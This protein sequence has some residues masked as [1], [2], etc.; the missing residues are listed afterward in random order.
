MSRCLV[1]ALPFALVA[2]APA[3]SLAAEECPDGWFCEDNAAPR[4]ASPPAPP[5]TTRPA[6]PPLPP[7]AYNSPSYPPPGYY[8]PE[9]H[10]DAPDNPP[11]KLR[12]RRSDREWGFNLHLEAAIL[13]NKP[14]RAANTG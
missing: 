12:R 13:G 14:E 11:A 8:E 2:L 9:M 6:P 7:S 1:F 3:T 4:P 10:F 5:G